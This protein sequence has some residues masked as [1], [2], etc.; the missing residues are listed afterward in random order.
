[1]IDFTVVF[2]QKATDCGQLFYFKNP[3]ILEFTLAELT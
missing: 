1:M 3:L 2:A